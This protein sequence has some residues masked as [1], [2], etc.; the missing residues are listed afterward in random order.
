MKNSKNLRIYKRKEKCIFFVYITFLLIVSY[1][2]VFFL[3]NIYSLKKG[4]FNFLLLSLFLIMFY[5]L[6]KEYIKNILKF[7][8]NILI[9]IIIFILS[10]YNIFLSLLFMILYLV[11]VKAINKYFKNLLK[12]K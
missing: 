3:F 4:I 11:F 2:F 9:I 1:C 6:F 5:I 10:Y 7:L 12:I 8:F